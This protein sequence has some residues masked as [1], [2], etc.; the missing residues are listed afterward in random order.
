MNGRGVKRLADMIGDKSCHAGLPDG[1]WVRSVPEPFYGMN[2]QA[3]W[4]VL[5]G[6]AHAVEWPKA[7]DLE[8]ALQE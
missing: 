4:E 7:G 8:K 6:R 1:R 2:L 5:R 3:A